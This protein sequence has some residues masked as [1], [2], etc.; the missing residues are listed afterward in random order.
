MGIDERTKK[1]AKRMARLEKANK[2]MF[3][4]FQDDMLTAAENRLSIFELKLGL[5]SK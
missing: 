1:V 2:E 3:H 5:N 4:I